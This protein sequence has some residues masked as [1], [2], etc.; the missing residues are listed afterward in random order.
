[1]RRTLLMR[2]T[3]SMSVLAVQQRRLAR[4]LSPM[5]RKDSTV[6]RL[7]GRMVHLPVASRKSEVVGRK[8]E[9]P[10]DPFMCTVK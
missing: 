6:I 9:Y 7:V 8:S 5:M 1:M 2:T 10:H 4:T 3:S